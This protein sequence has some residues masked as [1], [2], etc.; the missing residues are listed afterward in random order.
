MN[1]TRL[2]DMSERLTTLES[3]VSG[4]WAGLEDIRHLSGLVLG[5]GWL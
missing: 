2:S 4:L 5:S 1:C 3:K